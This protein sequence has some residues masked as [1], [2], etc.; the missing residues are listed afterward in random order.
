M[1][2]SELVGQQNQPRSMFDDSTKNVLP[3]DSPFDLT[4]P[5]RLVERRLQLSDAL[6]ERA[7]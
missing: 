2:F 7:P 1:S 6:M 5:K 3:A 4:K